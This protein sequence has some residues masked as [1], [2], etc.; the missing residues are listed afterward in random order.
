MIE[1][2]RFAWRP[3]AILSA[4]A[5]IAI[6]GVVHGLWSNRWQ[7]SEELA[8]AK[9]RLDRLS[10]NLGEW[11]SRSQT[12][13][14]A[15][16]AKA[17][18]TGYVRRLCT[19]PERSTQVGMLLM[20]G[21]PGPISVHTPQYCYSGAGYE[22]IGEPRLFDLNLKDGGKAKLFT[23]R[24]HKPKS[25]GTPPLR[26]FWTWNDGQGWRAP[27]FPRWTF[28][29]APALF[30]LYVMREMRS[31]DEPLNR[32][33]CIPFMLDALPRFQSELFNLAK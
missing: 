6:T 24:F 19:H 30:K 23:A 8:Q 29:R 17:E 3:L 11:R 12:I 1:R 5:L 28:R 21:A 14:E 25:P 18:L 13:S 15:S 10:M 16:A 27:E 9:A 2:L 22:M 33:A 4:F 31:L 20:C 32:D 26:I 7:K